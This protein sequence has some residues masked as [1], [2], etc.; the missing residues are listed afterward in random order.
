MI[1]GGSMPG[2]NKKRSTQDVIIFSGSIFMALFWVFDFLLDTILNDMGKSNALFSPSTHETFAH[3]L[4]IST[5]LFFVIYIYRILNQRRIMED[6]L[7]AS[8]KTAEFE[9]TRSE[10]ILSAIADAVSVQ[11]TGFRILYQNKAHKEMMGDHAGEFCY[12]AYQGKEKVCDGCHVALSF[13]DG[14]VHRRESSAVTPTGVKYVEVISSPLIAPD[15]GIIAGIETVRDVTERKLIERELKKQISAIEA[16]MDGIAILDA[17]GEYT[18]LNLSHARIYGYDSPGELIGKSWRILYLPDE[19]AMF[20][21]EIIPF[22]QAHGSWRGEALGNKKNGTT[23]PQEISLNLIGDEGMICVVRDI[24]D[25]KG[26]EET[27]KKQSDFMQRLIDTIPNPVYFKDLNGRYL[28]CNVAFAEVMGTLREEI[29]GKTAF[30]FTEL[31]LAAMCHLKDTELFRHPGVQSYEAKQRYADGTLRDVLFIKATFSEANGQPTGLVG[32]IIDITDRKEAEEEIARLNE[33]LR[34][35][36]IELETNNREL[37]AFNYSLSHDLRNHLTRVY[38]A[39]QAIE[40]EFSEKKDE[41]GRY[42]ARSICAAVGEMELLIDAMLVLSR[43]TRS[44][45]RCEEVDLG[46][47]AREISTT[48]QEIHPDRAVEFIIDPQLIAEGDPELLKVALENLLENAWKYTGR[49]A[50]A[51]IEFG[52]LDGDEQR[53]FFVRDNGAGF[54]MK[55]AG[56]LFKPFERLH[57]SAEFPG[58]GIGLAT[59]QRIIARHGGRTWGEGEVGKGATIYFSI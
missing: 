17:K 14:H 35:R 12:S 36:A 40:E 46:G 47:L 56:N 8:L 34:S 27:I 9:R 13:T 24:S 21:R 54:D 22:L 49:R 26:A 11:D 15:G 5:Q 30:E 41:N 20:E 57:S 58:T 37:E 45:M 48:L 18:Y 2:S 43:V 39:A 44:E 4:A 31:K 51:R 25:R 33:D 7:T 16:S 3:I 19:L 23:F 28:G 55:D 52:T 59:V 10:A 29:V 38:I 53:I 1:N 32:V 42:F 50:D 6:D